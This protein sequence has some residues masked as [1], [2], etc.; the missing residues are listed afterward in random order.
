MKKTI[1]MIPPWY[2]TKDNPI[3]GIFFKEQAE[4]LSSEYRFIV[5]RY[6][7]QKV[8]LLPYLAKALKGSLVRLEKGER[9]GDIEEYS[10]TVLIPFFS[11]LKEAACR[12]YLRRRNAEEGVGLFH[13]GG[14]RKRRY[15]LISVLNKKLQK[16]YD[17]VY[18]ISSQGIAYTAQLF[19]EIA[20]K[21]LVFGEHGPFPWPGSVVSDVQKESMERADCFFAISNDKIRQVML[22]NIRLKKI[23]YVGNLVDETVFEYRPVLHEHVTILIVAASSFYK[24]FD[25]FIETVDRLT[26]LTKVPF[27]VM[28][29]GYAANKGYSKNTEILEQ[30]VASSEFADRVEMIPSVPRE[31]MSELYN[32]ADCFVMTSIQEGQPVSAMEAG[33][34]GLPIFS[35]RCGGVEDYV[36][37]EVGRIVPILDCEK[38]AEYLRQFLEKEITFDAEEIRRA[39]VSRF[40]RKAFLENIKKEFDALLL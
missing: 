32:R 33:C 12:F 28:I 39:V 4:L 24:N 23:A 6:K 38:L 5:L 19:S 9:Y 25:M 15:K 13:S 40:G 29:A 34:C 37:D 16:E 11:V 27:R 31:K 36:T 26:G 35:T 21:P 8:F 14:Y 17:L 30:K 2:P 18:G 1:L 22:Q 10:G 3:S 20:Q 7:E